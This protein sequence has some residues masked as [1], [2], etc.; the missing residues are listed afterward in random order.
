MG[1]TSHM[2]SHCL[3]VQT[4]MVCVIFCYCCEVIYSTVLFTFCVIIL[5][6][7]SFEVSFLMFLTVPWFHLV[8]I[9]LLCLVYK[10][11]LCFC[12]LVVGVLWCVYVPAL[13]ASFSA[14]LYFVFPCCLWSLPAFFGFGIFYRGNLLNCSPGLTRTCFNNPW[15]T[16]LNSKPVLP[17]AAASR[18][19]LVCCFGT[20]IVTEQTEWTQYTLFWT[21]NLLTSDTL[22][23]IWRW[24]KKKHQIALVEVSVVR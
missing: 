9:T 20:Q 21:M 18:S 5:G 14:F 15:E 8:V 11:L 16:M 3:T 13:S 2:S 12:L 7:S 1:T 23:L 24:Q 17:V 19:N 10:S 4:D 6:P 22:I